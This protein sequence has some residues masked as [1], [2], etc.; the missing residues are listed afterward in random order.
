MTIHESI[1]AN[2]D[3]YNDWGNNLIAVI[4]ELAEVIN[5]PA[6]QKDLTAL[7]GKGYFRLPH[8][9]AHASVPGDGGVHPHQDRLWNAKLFSGLPDGPPT[10]AFAFY[11]PTGSTADGATIIYEDYILQ[12][13]ETK[14]RPVIAT[15]GTVVVGDFRLWHSRAPNRSD[16]PRWMVK[17][18]FSRA[19]PIWDE[20]PEPLAIEAISGNRRE[21]VNALHALGLYRRTVHM[22]DILAGV[23]DPYGEA[24]QHALWSLIRHAGE[25]S[26]PLALPILRQAMLHS[27]PYV[28]AF[29]DIA[30]ERLGV[31]GMRPEFGPDRQY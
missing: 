6:V 2:L 31:V 24:A 12:F 1:A 23:S 25:V 3:A 16:K 28:R 8:V 21:R 26:L 9:A 11:Y 18:L 5:A 17:F 29:A 14:A 30:L 22:L 10:V 19:E 20:A 15:P 4:P 27:D 13:D 7:L